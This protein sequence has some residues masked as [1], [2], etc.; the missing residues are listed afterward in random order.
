MDELAPKDPQA[1]R[2][3]SGKFLPGN[4]G[5]H[6][7]PMSKRTSLLRQAVLDAVGPDHVAGIIRRACKMALEGDVPAMRLVLERLL[8]RPRECPQE[9]AQVPIDLGSLATASDCADAATR[10]LQSFCGGEI[11]EQAAQTLL[12]G[13][14]LRAKTIELSEFEARLAQVEQAMARPPRSTWRGPR[15]PEVRPA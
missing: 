14:Q 2:D 11:A 5:G 7:N 6:G 3:A 8:G 10:I 12:G 15:T 13:V 9:A 1:F 4:P